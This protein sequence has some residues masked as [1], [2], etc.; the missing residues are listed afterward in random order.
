MYMS[1]R[2]LPELAVRDGPCTLLFINTGALVMS[3]NR[4][5]FSTWQP[6]GER[7]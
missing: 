4:E 5:P 1:E 7:R 6:Q 2:D 3:C